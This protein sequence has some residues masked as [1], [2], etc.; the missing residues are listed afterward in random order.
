M[1]SRRSARGLLQIG[2]WCVVVLAASNCGGSPSEPTPVPFSVVSVTPALGPVGA[3]LMIGGTGF[4]PGATVRVG[5]VPASATLQSSSSI[6][7]VAPAHSAGSVDVI[8]INAG[9]ETG[10]L[11][12]AFTYVP[13]TLTA[14]EAP[15]CFAGIQLRLTGGGF[16]ST[17]IVTFDGIRAAAVGITNSS[18]FVTIPPHAI[19]PVDITATNPSGETA[20]LKA[21]F[22]YGIPPTLALNVSTAAAGSPVQVSWT[23]TTT[24]GL[25]W[26]GLFRVGAA[27]ADWLKYFYTG[28]AKSG[29]S[30]LTMPLEPGQYEFRYLPND[31][32]V[33]IARSSLVTVTSPNGA[34]N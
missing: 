13:L 15:V 23:A 14:I 33:D 4:R 12:G 29:T 34:I 20:V 2:A 26:I 24:W 17:T 10:T 6:A 16:L 21:G 3:T 27:N 1:A 11:I 30:T 28:G 18:M 7:A 19:G 8:V 5:G 25:D 32:Y 22:T 9:G 31:S